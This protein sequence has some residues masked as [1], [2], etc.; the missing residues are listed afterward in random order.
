MEGYQ[1][2]VELLRAR[3]IN[4]LQAFVSVQPCGLP[5]RCASGMYINI[6]C[7]VITILPSPS[8]LP[9]YSPNPNTK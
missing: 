4:I 1:N 7:N 6:F 9:L 5:C 8:P 2:F 3:E